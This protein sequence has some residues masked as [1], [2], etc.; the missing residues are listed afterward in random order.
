MLLSYGLSRSFVGIETKGSEGRDSSKG[1]ALRQKNRRGGVQPGSRGAWGQQGLAHTGLSEEETLRM[2]TLEFMR[3]P[4]AN[5]DIEL[6]RRPRRLH[7]EW[8][9]ERGHRQGNLMVSGWTPDTWL[10]HLLR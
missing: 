6:G 9:G 8:R 4:G 7:S 5:V 10:C 2:I 1:K 3:A